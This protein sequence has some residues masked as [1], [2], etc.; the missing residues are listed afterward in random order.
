M[1]D[2]VSHRPAERSSTTVTGAIRGGLS[3]QSAATIGVAVRMLA[4]RGPLVA[5]EAAEILAASMRTFLWPLDGG[6]RIIPHRMDADIQTPVM[7]PRRGGDALRRE[8]SA[9]DSFR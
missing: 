3:A 1:L 9:L 8:A 5:L 2:T 6:V 7:W 4:S